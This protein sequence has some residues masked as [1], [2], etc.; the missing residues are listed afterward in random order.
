MDKEI[1]M[2]TKKKILLTLACA[3]LL[4]AGSVAGT[5]AWLTSTGTVT[6]T[7]TVGQVKITLDEAKV[8]PDGT[9]A[10]SADRVSGSNV[11]HL[12]PGHTY[13]KDPTIHVQANSED[14]Y[15]FVVLENGFANVID[16][17]TIEN[18]MENNNWKKLDG[19]NNNN[20]WYYAKSNN[21]LKTV[22][23]SASTQDISLFA[24]FKIKNDATNADLDSVKNATIKVKAYAIQ[25]DGM[26]EKTAADIWSILYNATQSSN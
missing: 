19:E 1:N 6:N 15:L 26:S 10:A 12:L 2:N 7:F 23:K 22:V 8:N 25:A 20:V 21:A 16:A 13:T 14:C 3:V 4:V 11:Y 9:T 24:N 5:L 18:Q 17:T